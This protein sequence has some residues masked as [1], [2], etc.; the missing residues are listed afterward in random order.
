MPRIQRIRRMFAMG[1]LASALVGAI[2]LSTNAEAA[3]ILITPTDDERGLDSFLDGNFICCHDDGLV[4]ATRNSSFE[5][6]VGLEF[7][8]AALPAGATIIS[9]TLTLHLPTATPMPN[10]SDVHG[11][12]GDGVI[13]ADDFTVSNLLTNF[14]V[15]AAGPV[16][17]AIAPVFIQALLTASE[18]FAGFILR[19]VTE[20][21]G[22]YTIWT[23]DSGF[24]HLYPT[25]AIEYEMVPEPGSLLLVGTA[26]I[27]VA[28]RIRR[29]VED[30]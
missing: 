1:L 13:A 23:T 6:R 30:R 3:V 7:A 21:S 16:D 28:R 19:N 22:V 24:E 27:L 29:T 18:D 2:G 9:T 5:E 15:N 17:I 10:S 8:L 12:A 11:Y 14:A 4:T 25:L 26:L 20:P